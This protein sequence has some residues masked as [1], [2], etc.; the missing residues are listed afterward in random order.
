MKQRTVQDEGN[1]TWTCVEAF[2]GGSQ[3]TAKAA[4]SLTKDAEGNVTVVCTP[5]GGEQSVRVSLPE[6]WIDKTSDQALLDAIQ[7]ARG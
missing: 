3:K 1:T 7:S 6:A 2:S 5:S 4:K